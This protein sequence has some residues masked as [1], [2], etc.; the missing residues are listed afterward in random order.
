MLLQQMQRSFRTMLVTIATTCLLALAATSPVPPAQY[1]QYPMFPSPNATEQRNVLPTEP[2]AVL[3]NQVDTTTAIVAEQ[4]DAAPPTSSSSESDTSESQSS[5]SSPEDTSE[6]SPENLALEQMI[7]P[8]QM[9]EL[10]PSTTEDTTSE[11]I[12]VAAEPQLLQRGGVES[13]GEMQDDSRGGDEIWH[14]RKIGVLNQIPFNTH[15]LVAVGFAPLAAT[16]AAPLETKVTDSVESRECLLMTDNGGCV[17]DGQ[18]GPTARDNQPDP[19]HGL[20]TMA[21]ERGELH[22]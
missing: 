14:K 11:E 16:R 20:Q 13:D 15:P 18:L 10:Q 8:D 4:T 6:E 7:P 1:E 3:R 17:Q 5:E 12:A 22:L 21:E 19:S 2:A 9:T